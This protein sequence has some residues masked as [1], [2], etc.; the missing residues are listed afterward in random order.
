MATPQSPLTIRFENQAETY[1]DVYFID[2][3]REWWLGRVA[4]GALSTLR[5]PTAALL[6]TS[7]Y[8][9]L[10]ALAGVPR[11][12]QAARDPHVALTIA[13]PAS[14]LLG[15]RWTFHK[16]ELASPEIFGQRANPR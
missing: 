3:L 16:T 9:R 4:P 15:Q 2:E 7:G 8:V 10:A 12:G 14:S 6:E 1:V 13:Q 11:S 5:V